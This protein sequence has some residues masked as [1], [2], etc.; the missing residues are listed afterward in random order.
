MDGEAP[1]RDVN[2]IGATF[3]VLLLALFALELTRP[4][5]RRGVRVGHLYVRRALIMLDA[6]DL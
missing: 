6:L 5:A 3:V 2:R 4:V 1:A